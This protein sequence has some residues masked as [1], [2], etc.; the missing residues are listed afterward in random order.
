MELATS[1]I[2]V[3]IGSSSTRVGYAGE[4]SPSQLLNSCIGVREIYSSAGSNY[5]A[6]SSQTAAARELLFPLNFSERRD[7]VEVV[8][9]LYPTWRGSSGKRDG[10]TS[11]TYT[12]HEEAFETIV[13]LS[14]TGKPPCS[15][16]RC[17]K[18]GRGSLGTLST[19]DTMPSP[20]SVLRLTEL[21]GMGADLREQPVL[22][23]EP[24]IHCREIREKMAEILFEGLQVGC[25]YTAKRALLSCVAAGRSSALVI[26]MGASGLSLAPVADSFVLDQ[27]V[28]EWPVG[29]D[30]MSQLLGAILMGHNLPV[31][32]SFARFSAQ[33]RVSKRALDKP[34]D[35]DN[36]H[37]S[38]MH[39]SRMQTL[40]YLKEGLCRVADDPRDVASAR[41]PIALPNQQQQPKR[42]GTAAAFT[43]EGFI[44][45]QLL[46][47]CSSAAS[48]AALLSGSSGNEGGVMELPDGTRLEAEQVAMKA[49]RGTLFLCFAFWAVT[50]RTGMLMCSAS[51]QL[52]E[53]LFCP[54]LLASLPGSGGG[55]PGIPEAVRQVAEAV[56]AEGNRDILSILILTG[57][58]SS[59]PGMVERL[60]RELV[61]DPAVCGGQKVRLLAAPGSLERRQSA[62]I[63]GSILSSLS[64][65]QAA[66]CS[67]E[68]YEEHGPSVVQRKC[69]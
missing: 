28:S 58:C 62:W 15:A 51:P 27:H 38:Y 66:W 34:G 64:S 6:E 32:P 16:G 44:Q 26:D 13:A 42:R 4:G 46:F 39:W 31:F 12:L 1:S 54:A 43:P 55:F 2:V 41:K 33:N 50:L 67:R 59:I 18:G 9:A 21:C 52:P 10:D 53:V 22:L 63:G 5:E 30:A 57:G 45:S 14:C 49:R 29:G 69:Y 68:E 48:A 7:G 56:E 20:D 37:P 19:G 24:N 35:W 25:L 40:S 11:P 65:F 61:E 8:P 60:N 3:D 17:A 23:T 47:P 36:V